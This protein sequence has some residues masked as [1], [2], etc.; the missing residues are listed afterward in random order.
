M[1]IKKRERKNK[2]NIFTQLEGYDHY[3]GLD[4]SQDGY[5]LELLQNK[6][7]FKMRNIY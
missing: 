2:L 5:S 1:E 4:W 7:L 3:L 6:K